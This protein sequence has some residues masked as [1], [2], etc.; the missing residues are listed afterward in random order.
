MMPKPLHALVAVAALA[1]M[2]MPALAD[3]AFDAVVKQLSGEKPKFADRHQKLLEERY[4]LSNKPAQGVTMSRGKPVQAGVRVKLPQ[5]MTWDKLAAMTPDEIKS[6]EPLA[7]RLLSAAAP[8]SRSG[9]HDLPEAADRRDQEADRPRP[10]ALR[11]RL[12][13]AASTCCRSSR[14]RSILTTR[15]DLGDVSKGQLVTLANFYDLFKDI[16]NPKQLEGLRLLVTPFPQQQFNATDDRR[17]LQAALG[18]QPASTATPT[19]TRT[20][21]RTPSA[22]SART[23]IATASTRRRCA[24]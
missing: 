16:L 10:D 4:D 19:A 14:R 9:R 5:G 24:A 20:P 17:S 12:R 11:S 13:P 22:T 23:S 18:R 15:P 8:A 21:R 6:Q 3:P 7:G 1:A 2:T